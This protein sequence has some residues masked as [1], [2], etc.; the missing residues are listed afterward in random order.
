[1]GLRT[2][3]TLQESGD[4]QSDLRVCLRHRAETIRDGTGIRRV[5][6]GTRLVCENTAFAFLHAV[7]VVVRVRR[8]EWCLLHAMLIGTF[9]LPM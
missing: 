8:A 6:R 4:H 2:G 3:G 5:L 1:M 9:P 7:M